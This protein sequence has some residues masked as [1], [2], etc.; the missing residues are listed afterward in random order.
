M[1]IVSA[2]RPKRDEIAAMI[3]I[4]EDRIGAAKSEIAALQQAARLFDPEGGGDEDTV[5]HREL[6]GVRE[7]EERPPAQHKV[8]ESETGTANG[9]LTLPLSGA[10]DNQHVESVGEQIP[11]EFFYFNWP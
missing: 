10:R 4:Y 1:H 11:G 8:W 6:E 7:Q 3:S 2:L 9:Q 5:L